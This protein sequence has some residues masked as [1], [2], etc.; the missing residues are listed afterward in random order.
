MTKVEILKNH[1]NHALGIA[2]TDGKQLEL[3]IFKTVTVELLEAITNAPEKAHNGNNGVV[4][5][6]MAKGTAIK[7]TCD[8]LIKLPFTTCDIDNAFTENKNNPNVKKTT[9][10]NL[11]EDWVCEYLNAEQND[12][13]NTA[14]YV[15]GDMRYDGLDIQI[16]YNKGGFAIY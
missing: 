2:V 4:K 12:K 3:A 6:S 5:Y 13:Q 9:R 1:T 11:F 16:K 10:G 7:E 14:Y 8:I 15:S